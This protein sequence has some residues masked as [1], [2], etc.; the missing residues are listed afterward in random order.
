MPEKQLIP[1]LISLKFKYLNV[2]ASVWCIPNSM[3]SR[4]KFIEAAT[5]YTNNILYPN[6]SGNYIS[7]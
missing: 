5:Y 3:V 4:H 2:T 1:F 6:I 7:S